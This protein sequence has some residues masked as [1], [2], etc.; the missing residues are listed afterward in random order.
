MDNKKICIDN[1]TLGKDMLLV[2]VR[3]S[4]TYINGQ[5]GAQN[6]YTYDVCLPEHNLDKLS[7]RIDGEQLV[8]T[9]ESK[10]VPVE[11][12]GLVVRPYVTRDGRLAYSATATA[13]KIV[14]NK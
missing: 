1:R 14:Q 7:I 6:G 12:A 5:R 9:P 3:P 10:Y 11:I 4:Y 8:P 2:A 13:V